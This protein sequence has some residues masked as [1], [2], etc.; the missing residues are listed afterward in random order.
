MFKKLARYT[1]RLSD[2]ADVCATFICWPTAGALFIL[3][4]LEIILRYVFL[5]SLDWNN[6]VI[7]LCFTWA[8]LI[9]FSIALKRHA[10]IEFRFLTD[11]LPSRIREVVALF[12]H[13]IC[14]CFFV[15]VAVEGFYHFQ[16][17]ADSK[18]IVLD[19]SKKWQVLPLP[20]TGVFMT[21]HS[22]AILVKKIDSF[23]SG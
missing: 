22:L 1:L 3:I 21:L 11:R 10:H 20:L 23:V 13:L 7:R 19:M 5:T 4:L 14:F 12:S 2:L 15:Y 6:D 8:V 16:A 17:S 9:S 18:F